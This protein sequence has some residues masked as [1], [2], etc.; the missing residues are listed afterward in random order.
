MFEEYLQDAYEFLIIADSA[1]NNSDN[2]SAKRYYRAS[3]FYAAS[4][5]EAF[6]NYIGD[7][8]EKAGSLPPYETAFL[9]DK[10]LV[11]DPQ[12]SDLLEQIRHYGIDDKLK[13]LLRKFVPNYDLGKSESWSKFV[14]FKN[15]RDTLVHPRQS[16]DEYEIIYYQTKLRNGITGI[17]KLMNDILIGLFNKPLRKQILDLIPE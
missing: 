11:F 1:A 4:A 7:S 6:V 8:F 3:V 2:R 13:F 15:F 12:K 17:I 5:M 9:N 14:E 10:Q 16:E